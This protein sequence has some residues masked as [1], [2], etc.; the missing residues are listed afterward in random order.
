[1]EYLL[2]PM[3]SSQTGRVSPRNSS[4]G[5]NGDA[6]SKKS[7][8]PIHP[9]S[10]AREVSNATMSTDRS[11]SQSHSRSP[12]TPTGGAALPTTQ[13]QQQQQSNYNG[14]GNGAAAAGGGSN[15]P[16]PPSGGFE[17]G[18]NGGMQMSSIREERETSA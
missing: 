5:G 2:I 6:S 11:A 9:S 7:A 18:G 13:Q 10:L 3:P 17:T 15:K 16:S 8:S 14:A 1:M 4:R 12:I